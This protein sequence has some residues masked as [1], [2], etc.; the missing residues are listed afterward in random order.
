MMYMYRI[1]LHSGLK[2]WKVN[3]HK[4]Y[5]VPG[6]DLLAPVRKRT[7]RAE[8]AAIDLTSKCMSEEAI[9]DL[10]TQLSAIDRVKTK[11]HLQANERLPNTIRTL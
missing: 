11:V 1:V 9:L 10:K 3:S 8:A 2:F 4:F 5:A 7:K 6:D